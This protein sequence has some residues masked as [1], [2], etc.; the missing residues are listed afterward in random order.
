MEFLR[1]ININF[2]NTFGQFCNLVSDDKKSLFFISWGYDS[3]ILLY[4]WNETKLN[5]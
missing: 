2:V 4:E 3:K 1:V 5:I